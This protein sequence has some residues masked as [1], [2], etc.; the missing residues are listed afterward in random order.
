MM[1]ICF[2][3][4]YQKDFTSSGTNHAPYRPRW[5]YFLHKILTKWA[6]VSFCWIWQISLWV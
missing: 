1:N 5:W 6:T 2:V 4:G 3:Q